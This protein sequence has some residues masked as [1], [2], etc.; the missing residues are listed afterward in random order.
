MRDIAKDELMNTVSFVFQN[1]KLIKA[2]IIDN[3]KI[4]RPDATKAEVMQVLKTAQCMDIIEKF[5]NGADT[6]NGGAQTVRRRFCSKNLIIPIDTV[7]KIW[8]YISAS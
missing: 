5:P 8:Y 7:S 1:S 6:V 2:S 4:G 3:V